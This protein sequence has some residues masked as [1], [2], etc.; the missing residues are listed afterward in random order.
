MKNVEKQKEFLEYEWHKLIAYDKINKVYTL[1][2]YD[3]D[4]QK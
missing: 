3:V 4:K 1:L 2:K